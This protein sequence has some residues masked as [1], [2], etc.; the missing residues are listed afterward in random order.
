MVQIEVV[1]SEESIKR[2]TNEIAEEYGVSADIMH[3]VIKCESNYNRYAL[4]DHGKSR[5]LVQIHSDYHDVSDK[6]AYDSEYAITF[7]AKKLKEGKGNLW[8]CY[9]KL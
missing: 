4:G 2:R 3:K 6:D 1:W 5:G 9:R 8:T 7:L